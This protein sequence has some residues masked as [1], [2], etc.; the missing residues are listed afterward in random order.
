MVFGKVIRGYTEVVT[1]IA[2]IPTDEKDRPSVPVVI[3]HC[4]ELEL[5]KPPVQPVNKAKSRS[6]LSETNNL[7]TLPA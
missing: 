3:T 7:D 4:G 6:N 2:T 5:R 1:K